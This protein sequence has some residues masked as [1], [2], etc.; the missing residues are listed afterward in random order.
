MSEPTPILYK[1]WTN[2]AGQAACVPDPQGKFVLK[3]DYDA[4][5]AKHDAL[6]AKDAALR[7]AA[8]DTAE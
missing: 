2:N 6:A 3:A 8:D 7:K 1:P 4:L 5:K